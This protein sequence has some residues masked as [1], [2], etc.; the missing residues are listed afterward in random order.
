[1]ETM[2]TDF[3]AEEYQGLDFKDL[4][5]PG[6]VGGGTILACRPLIV[7]FG[8]FFMIH[9]HTFGNYPT[10]SPLARPQAQPGRHRSR[11]LVHSGAEWEA[12]LGERNA[13]PGHATP[14]DQAATNTSE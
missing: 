5:A 4:C 11:C 1:M 8:S 3:S 12:G 13:H 7:V 6:R 9:P 14:S 10:L 2:P